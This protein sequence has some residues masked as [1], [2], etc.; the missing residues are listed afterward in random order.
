MDLRCACQCNGVISSFCQKDD[1]SN[2]GS[3][4][5]SGR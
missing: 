3:G 1:L 2:S 4:G 5:S